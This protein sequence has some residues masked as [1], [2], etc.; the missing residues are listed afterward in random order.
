MLQRLVNIHL[1]KDNRLGI[2]AINLNE[3]LSERCFPVEV[4]CFCLETLIHIF[5]AWYLTWFFK[6][7]T[8]GPPCQLIWSI[9]RTTEGALKTNCNINWNTTTKC[10]P[11][12]CHM[13]LNTWYHNIIRIPHLAPA[14]VTG[15]T[16]TLVLQ[17]LN[18]LPHPFF[19][20]LPT[21]QNGIHCCTLEYVY[22]SR[23]GNV[24]N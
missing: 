20:F 18:R 12:Q 2:A 10:T 14:D 3:S 7:V 6:N 8:I 17:E 21:L 16:R 15:S 24:K 1:F 19:Q 4:V 5:W 22:W 11:Y 13:I 9:F 23:L